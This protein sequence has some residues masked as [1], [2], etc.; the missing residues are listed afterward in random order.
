[1]GTV[2][3]RSYH[4]QKKRKSIGSRVL[5]A[6]PGTQIIVVDAGQGDLFSVITD[7]CGSGALNL[8]LNIVNAH[9]GQT[10][11]VRYDSNDACD[12]PTLVIQLDGTGITFTEPTVNTI[13]DHIL[14]I[15]IFDASD[16]AL[17]VVADT[18][19]T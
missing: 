7:A 4:G 11:W 17:V 9:D 8:T 10:L 5:A 6:D 12:D 1:M 2:N 13:G 14:E 19:I 3:S 15:K 16:A 18:E